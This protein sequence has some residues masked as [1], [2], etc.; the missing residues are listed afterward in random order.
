M[1]ATEKTGLLIAIKCVYENED[2]MLI[3]I[4]GQVIRQSIKGIRSIGR[5][6]QGVRLIRLRENDKIAD[7][8]RVVEE[9]E[10]G[11]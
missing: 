8:A 6:T 10:N 4:N 11:Q 2:L 3:T 7:V 1:K 5:N 9:E